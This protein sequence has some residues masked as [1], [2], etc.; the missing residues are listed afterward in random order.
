MNRLRVQNLSK[1]YGKHHVFNDFSFELKK[2]IC[3][4][5]ATNGSGK[6]TLLTI[7]AGITHFDEGEIFIDDINLKTHAM[8]YKAHSC[9]VPVSPNF[10]PECRVIDFFELI[11]SIKKERILP[12]DLLEQFR[13]TSILKQTITQLSF[14]TLKKVFLTTLLIGKPR[15]ILLD[16]PFDGL[17]ATAQKILQNNLNA[18]DDRIIL[19]ASHQTKLMQQLAVSSELTIPSN[20]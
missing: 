10:Y 19:I 1:R 12:F 15:L 8:R 11:L 14:G 17:D 18:L 3:W 20:V 16:E 9:F 4:L 7:C 5:N 13:L 2:G 6:T